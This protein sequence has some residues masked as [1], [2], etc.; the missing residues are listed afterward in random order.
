LGW[1]GLGWVGLGWVGL[2]WVGLG[3]VGLDLWS[4]KRVQTTLPT[5]NKIN[6][7][8][9]QPL[10]LILYKP[11]VALSWLLG[12]W[13][14]HICFFAIIVAESNPFTPHQ[15]QSILVLVA[16]DVVSPLLFCYHCNRK[17][18]LHSQI[19]TGYHLCQLVNNFL[20]VCSGSGNI[21]SHGALITQ[22]T[23]CIHFFQQQ[24]FRSSG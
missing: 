22:R 11:R 5:L 1:V 16:W 19:E 9:F 23:N 7:N 15:A 21:G 12:M 18:P 3:W 4:A 6:N 17:Q 24:G 20:K 13:L 2:G 14:S 10:S 8:D